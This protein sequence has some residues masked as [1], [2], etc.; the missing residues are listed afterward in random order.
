MFDIAFIEGGVK[1][2]LGEIL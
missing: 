2:V 1:N